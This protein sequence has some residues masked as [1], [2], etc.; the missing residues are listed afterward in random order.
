MRVYQTT[1]ILWL[2]E[3]GT[4]L[5]PDSLVFFFDNRPNEVWAFVQSSDPI[6][7]SPV[8]ALISSSLRKYYEVDADGIE[9]Q[10]ES[11]ATLLV[12]NLTEESDGDIIGFGIHDDKGKFDLGT[13]SFSIDGAV[14]SRLYMSLTGAD[15]AVV[16]NTAIGC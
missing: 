11:A 3:L 9:F 5:Y 16:L 1:T 8:S 4:T 15:G 10:V 13:A 7:L 12:T 6:L 2:Q 14:T